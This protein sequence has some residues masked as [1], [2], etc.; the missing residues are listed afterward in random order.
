M[1]FYMPRSALV[2][3]WLALAPVVALANH[4][5]FFEGGAF[6]LSATGAPPSSQTLTQT[7]LPA[8]AVLGGQRNITL[9]KTDG[10]NGS[11]VN[12]SLLQ[13]TGGNADDNDVAV[14][15]SGS[16]NARGSLQ[17]RYGRGGDLNAN[18]LDIPNSANDWDRIRVTFGAASTS[19]DL[20]VGLFSR[21]D[22]GLA[23][24]TRTYQ[25]GPGSLD[26]LYSDFSDGAGL[27]SAFLRNIDQAGLLFA[28]NNST[29]N[30]FSFT[31]QSFNRNGLVAPAAVPEPGTLLLL[32]VALAG[33]VLVPRRARSQSRPL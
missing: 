27:S 15:F 33:M 6:S 22:G 30:N 17:F 28:S 16:G 9:T 10:R 26:F 13:G 11:A 29:A 25:G 24:L 18:F 20:T 3:A 8:G 4:V 31:I 1:K 2:A 14:L 32:G 12:A 19:I 7:G 5:D 21:E 23:S